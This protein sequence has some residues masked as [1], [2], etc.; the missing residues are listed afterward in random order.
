MPY[1]YVEVGG[2]LVGLAFLFAMWVL[3]ADS[4]CQAWSLGLYLLSHPTGPG[5]MVFK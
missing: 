4:G 2:Q 1:I 5:E 3:E